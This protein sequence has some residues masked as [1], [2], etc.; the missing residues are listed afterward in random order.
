MPSTWI[1]FEENWIKRGSSSKSSIRL[2]VIWNLGRLKVY[3]PLYRTGEFPLFSLTFQYTDRCRA[4]TTS[5]V[6]A[7]LDERLALLKK[8]AKTETET[9]KGHDSTVQRT[10]RD[11][12]DK[13]REVKLARNNPT[14]GPALKSGPTA[15]GLALAEKQKEK[16]KEVAALKAQME[17][18]KEK[19][20]ER[21]REKAKGNE[22][23]VDSMDVDEPGD[24]GKGR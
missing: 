7:T 11:V 3:L 2:A 10:L 8:Q 13:Q 22:E 24:K 14:G 1:S 19:E 18:D 21:E 12:L 20:R 4:S 15:A 5:A 17:K 9:L 16:E 23:N 6:L